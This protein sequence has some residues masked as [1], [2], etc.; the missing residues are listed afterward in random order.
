[1]T[2]SSA[3]AVKRSSCGG[4][5]YGDGSGKRV[6]RSQFTEWEEQALVFNS[7]HGDI[8]R[9]YASVPMSRYLLHSLS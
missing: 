1:M 3:W 2:E 7:S 6:R 8:D 9:L 4:C 5:S